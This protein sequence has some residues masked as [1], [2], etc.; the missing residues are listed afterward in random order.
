MDKN[1]KCNRLCAFFEDK[2][3]FF[4]FLLSKLYLYTKNRLIFV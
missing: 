2:R 3:S 1:Y 4:C